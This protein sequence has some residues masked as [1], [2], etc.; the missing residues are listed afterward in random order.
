MGLTANFNISQIDGFITLKIEAL[1]KKLVKKLIDSGRQFVKLARENGG[2]N[3]VT[4]NLRSSI[5]FMVLK[6]GVVLNLNFRQ[7]GSGTK[8]KIEAIA[9]A[10]GLAGTTYNNGYVLLVVAG[11]KYAASVESRGK[12]V[13]TG[14]SQVVESFLK[15][16]ITKIK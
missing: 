9:F 12:D 1:E 6:D 15:E 7:V 13:I 11:M 3:N 10:Q 5:G 16:A 14:S 4:D 8:G 2:Y